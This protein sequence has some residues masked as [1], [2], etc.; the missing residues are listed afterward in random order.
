[1]GCASKSQYIDIQNPKKSHFNNMDLVC[2]KDVRHGRAHIIEVECAYIPYAQ[3]SKN[4]SGER[5]H[6]DSLMEWNINNPK[7]PQP[8]LV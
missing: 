2:K 1:M 6:G 4:I 8:Y 3:I 7:P 5:N